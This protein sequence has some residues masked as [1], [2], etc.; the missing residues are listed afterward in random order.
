MFEFLKPHLSEIASFVAGLAGGSLLTLRI[1]RHQRLSNNAN[2]SD[3]RR[4]Q[5][6]GDVVG[7]DKIADPA[8]PRRNT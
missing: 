5:A 1:T 3:Q 7:R 4:S 2:I 6:G 8:R